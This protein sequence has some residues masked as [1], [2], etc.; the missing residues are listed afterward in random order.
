MRFQAKVEVRRR[1]GIADPE[2]ATIER[3]MPALGFQEV[4]GLEAGRWFRFE[5]D[6][7]DES[8]ATERATMLADRLLANPVIEESE[9]T[10]A[11]VTQL[12]ER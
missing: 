4:Q 12:S 11:P 2:A 8:S 7:G 9:V 10:V 1:R 6:A 3:A 5:L